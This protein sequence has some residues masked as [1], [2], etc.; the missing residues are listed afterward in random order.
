MLDRRHA[1]RSLHQLL[2]KTPGWCERYSAPY[3]VI[4]ARCS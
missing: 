4:I 3:T 2:L 1:Q